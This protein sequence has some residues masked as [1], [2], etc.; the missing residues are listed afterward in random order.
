MLCWRF[1]GH[2][3]PPLV[4]VGPITRPLNSRPVY[5][6]V[7]SVDHFETR[8]AKLTFDCGG[9]YFVVPRSEFTGLFVSWQ[10]TS[11]DDDEPTSWVKRLE[12]AIQNGSGVHEFVV[13]VGHED[14]V[15]LPFWQVR[16]VL[17]TVNNVN[18]MLMAKE[19]PN[20]QKYQWLFADV[21]RENATLLAD[22]RG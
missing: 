6:P 15:N 21:H 1:A 9:G 5:E 2:Y 22:Y 18:V 13:R 8:F 7:V 17:V 11:I 3:E 4:I 16:I 12:H 14:C 20:P 19:C 10:R